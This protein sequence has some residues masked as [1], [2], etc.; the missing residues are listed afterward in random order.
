MK[1]WGSVDLN[2][3]DMCFSKLRMFGLRISTW[4]GKVQVKKES[5]EPPV[6]SVHHTLG[7]K[8]QMGLQLTG[9]CSFLI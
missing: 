7:Y 1:E 5:V 4:I 2:M 9:K 3:P 6:L 8:P